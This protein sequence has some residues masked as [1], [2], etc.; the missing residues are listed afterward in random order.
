[1]VFLDGTTI[2]AHHKT[3][4]AA[5]KK[6][7]ES[8]KKERELLADLAPRSASSWMVMAGHCLSRFRPVRRTNC[9]A[10]MPCLMICLDRPLTLVVIVVMPRTFSVRI[11]GCRES[12]PVIPSR[13][14]VPPVACPKWAYMHRFLVENLYARFKEWRAVA[15]RYEK[16]AFPE[17]FCKKLH[18][19]SFIRA[20]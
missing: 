8:A 14:N 11:S 10:F 19:A 17:A 4:R 18:R 5:K 7:T 1:M 16:T 3:A 12:R 2:H 20:R 13:K 15:T 9:H 6:N